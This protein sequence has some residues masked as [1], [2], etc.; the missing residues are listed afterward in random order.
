V[1]DREFITFLKS[2]S[3]DL[4]ATMYKVLAGYTK[5]TYG[6]RSYEYGALLNKEAY[7]CLASMFHRHGGDLMR[8]MAVLDDHGHLI[9]GKESRDGA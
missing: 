6:C 9:T 2:H 4:E 7:D 5:A 8:L 3:Y 1:S